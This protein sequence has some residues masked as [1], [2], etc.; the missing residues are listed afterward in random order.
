MNS[1]PLREL[2]H[3]GQSVWLDYIE[4]DF[5]ARGELARLVAE[6]NVTGVTSNPAIFEK[7]IAGGAGYRDALKALAGRSSAET[8]ETLMVEDIRHACEV[9]APVHARADMQ[10]GFVSIEVSPELAHDEAATIDAALRLSRRIARPNLMIKVPGTPAGLRATEELIARGLSVNVTLLFAVPTYRNVVDAYARGLARRHAAGLPLHGIASVASFFVSRV[11]TL[12]DKLLADKGEAG[13]ALAGR[14]AIA[15]AKL[16]YR[17]YQS[18]QDSRDWQTLAA[19]GAQPQRLLWA[20]TGTKSP[21]MSD[22]VYVDELIGPDTVNT[23]P[24]ATLD[25]FRDHG[26]ARATLTRGYDEADATMH[27]LAGLGI[28]IEQVT[29]TLLQEGLVL[30]QEAY[31]RLL[32][33]VGST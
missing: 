8:V 22:V 32:G 13:A 18:Q 28:S 4:R 20:S 5:L 30:F 19:A 33:A 26:R 23:V 27:A 29:D 11:D 17:L 24:P 1:N 7:A 3:H 16:A 2:A 6:D 21:L 10:D 9:L 15:N 31:R 12:V 14:A 25:A